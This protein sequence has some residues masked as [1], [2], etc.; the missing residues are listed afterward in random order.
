MDRLEYVHCVSCVICVGH[1]V[2]VGASDDFVRFIRWNPAHRV[3]K[4]GGRARR[5][6]TTTEGRAP[7][8]SQSYWMPGIPRN[9]GFHHAGGKAGGAANRRIREALIRALGTSR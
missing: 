6:G 1:E 3:S 8:E 9:A 7:A 4:W 5:R 2:R